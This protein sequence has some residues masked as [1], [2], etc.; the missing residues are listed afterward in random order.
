MFIRHPNRWPCHLVRVKGWDFRYPIVVDFRNEYHNENILP[1]PD[2]FFVNNIFRPTYDNN[3]QIIEL[4]LLHN[5]ES[6]TKK[7]LI[8]KKKIGNVQLLM[9]KSNIKI[10]I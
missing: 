5:M 7:Q 1:L 10:N 2:S 9:K 4:T 3:K 6:N 8:D